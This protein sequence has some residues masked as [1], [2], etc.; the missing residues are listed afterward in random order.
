M[1][2]VAEPLTLLAVVITRSQVVIPLPWM[3]GA[4]VVCAI[5]WA[6]ILVDMRQHREPQQQRDSQKAVVQSERAA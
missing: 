4:T 1:M 5:G 3:I 6:L 2:P